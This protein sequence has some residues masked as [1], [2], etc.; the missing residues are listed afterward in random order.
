MSVAV[1]YSNMYF[2]FIVCQSND[3]NSQFN[4]TKPIDNYSKVSSSDIISLWM[5]YLSLL[6]QEQRI[7]HQFNAFS[8]YSRISGHCRKLSKLNGFS[9]FEQVYSLIGSFN[10]EKKIT[11]SRQQRIEMMFAVNIKLKCIFQYFSAFFSIVQYFNQPIF[12][13][14]F[15]NNIQ[16]YICNGIYLPNNSKAFIQY[17]ALNECRPFNLWGRCENPWKLP[18]IWRG[19]LTK[20]FLKW[21]KTCI[22]QFFPLRN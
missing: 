12:F 16:L 7:F 9:R 6:T 13:L 14:P 19:I 17:K 4:W 18:L 3:P 21:I 22:I 15:E 8:E 2:I 11:M 1:K 10:R 20:V 5:Q